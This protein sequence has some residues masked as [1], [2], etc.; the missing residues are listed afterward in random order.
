VSRITATSLFRFSTWVTEF[1]KRRG[2]SK[3]D[4]RP[5]YE[6]QATTDEYLDLKGLISEVADAKG[7]S[8]DSAA[9]A[10]FS[11]FCAEWY[12]REYL[13]QD[14][15]SWEGIWQLLGFQFSAQELAKIVPRGLDGY[16]KR[17]IRFY[18]SERRNFLGSLFSEGGLPFLLLK[19]SDS[20]FQALFSRILKQ[21]DQAKLLG[22]NTTQLIEQQ[23][24][25][26]NLPH[27]FSEDTSVELIAAMADEL[28]SLVHLYDLST[29]LDPVMTLETRNPNWRQTF[30]IPLDDETGSELLNGLLKA[31]S[32]ESIARKTASN[33]WRC[34]H[35]WIEEQPGCLKAQVSMPAD[36]LFTLNCQAPTTRF[37]IAIAEGDRPIVDLG[38]GYALIENN[39]ARVRLRKREVIFN[40]RNYDTELFL[41]AMAGGMI[42]ASIRIENS[43]VAFGD[44]PIGFECINE[45]WMLCGQASF[46]S[47][48]EE[49]L[50]VLPDEVHADEFSE[51]AAA[52]PIVCSKA[53]IRVTGK[54]EFNIEADEIYRIRTG[55]ASAAGMMLDLEGIPLAFPTKP[56]LVFLGL[57]NVKWKNTDDALACNGSDLFFS[58]KAQNVCVLQ[59]LLGVQYLSVRNKNNESLLRRKVGILPT[60]F[61]LELKSGD[62]PSQGSILLYGNQTCLTQILDDSINVKRIKHVDHIEIKL[63][64]SGLPPAKFQ[65]E[66]T[67]NLLGDPVQVEVPFPS[68]GCMAFDAE[69][70]PLKKDICLGDLLGTRVYLFGRNGIPT[71]F[72]LELRLRSNSARHAHFTW[73]YTAGDKPLEISLFNIRDQVE[74]LLSLK[75]GIDQVVELR[76]NGNGQDSYYRIS[77]HATQMNMDYDRQIL[78]TSNFKDHHS[79]YP[80][81]VLML[82]HEPER[83]PTPLIQ[84]LSDGV[85]TGEYELP[86]LVQRNGPWLVIP[87]QGSDLSFRPLFI[88]G[89]SFSNNVGSISDV[90]SLQKAVLAFDHKM[91][92]SSFVAVLDAMAINPMH[93]GWHF[94]HA[95]YDQFGYMP[96]ATFEVWKALIS[97]PRALAMSLFKFEMNPEFL[98]RLESEFPVLWEFMSF[99]DIKLIG[100]RFSSFLKVKGV[101]DESVKILIA[102]MYSKLADV[103]PAYGGEVQSYLSTNVI[104]PDASLPLEIF[105]GITF[106]WYQ[107]LIREH[108]DCDRPQFGSHLL[109]AWFES[110]ESNMIDFEP[111]DDYRSI[112]YL[113]TFAA[114]VASGKANYS[115]VFGSKD[116]AIF[117]LRQVRDF[118]SRWFNSV[119][120]YCLLSHTKNSEK[121][122]VSYD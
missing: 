79:I 25:K 21:Y 8:R 27:A 117:F 90:Q 62:K 94:L 48:S 13:R 83:K 113:P 106:G 4:Q 78:F 34:G 37:D 67:P 104:G 3:P 40:R 45:R 49:V 112:V 17:P 105:K 29:S 57:P 92:T 118:D 24:V 1:I 111:E 107:D 64:T 75:A 80:E 69:G 66:I 59:E 73:S 58:G 33:G 56:S 30:P 52:G 93:S 7:F 71:K 81:P 60:D 46:N 18:E 76:I 89:N 115:E 41:V 32:K 55:L 84:R 70:N 110:R 108:C 10:C 103:F 85:P 119:Y 86:I 6:Y 53:S 2:L 63:E 82:L 100:Q 16:W 77:K 19:D 65:L 38:A 121:E 20:R 98:S 88:A 96:L 91:T 9:C 31:A 22:L 72:E 68:S 116:E 120:Q 28:V 15:W 97:H 101:P 50:I 54:S 23:I 95:L 11:L 61:K 43:S 36:V 47:K 42:I 26:A 99:D 74:D 122:V 39:K 51:I 102:G 5:L 109:K 44:V 114:A 12:R 35:F 87:K 14:G